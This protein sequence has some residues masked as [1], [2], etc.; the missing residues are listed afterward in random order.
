MLVSRGGSLHLPLSLQ[1]CSP[2]GYTRVLRWGLPLCM[3]LALTG[4]HVSRGA[5][6]PRAQ[7][8]LPLPFAHPGGCSPPIGWV[9]GGSL[10]TLV[11]PFLPFVLLKNVFFWYAGFV[12]LTGWLGFVKILAVKFFPFAEPLPL[13]PLHPLPFLVTLD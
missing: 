8:C 10:Y 9:W 1:R 5:L 12:S 7:V 13:P 3:A 6:P 2:G 4:F 11:T